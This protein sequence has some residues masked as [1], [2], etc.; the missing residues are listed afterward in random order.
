MRITNTMIIG[1]VMRNYNSIT[2]LLDRQMQQLSSGRRF[3]VPSD[4]P[5]RMLQAMRLQTNMF[6]YSQYLKNVSDARSWVE[7][8][9]TALAGA[10][11]ILQ[12]VRE[13]T[14]QAYNDP[15][16]QDSREATAIE[17]EVLLGELK[18]VGNT[19]FDGRY[20]FNGQSTTKN[21]YEMSKDNE[22][23]IEFVGDT[24]EGIIEYEI[25]PGINIE[26]NVPP[27]K[28]FDNGSVNILDELRNLCDD[29]RNP[30]LDLVNVVGRGT[31]SLGILQNDLVFQI[32][33][34]RDN[35]SVTITIT[36]GSS[37]EEA[38]AQ[39]N[40][41]LAQ[42]GINQLQA[43][44]SPKKQLI[45]T[46]KEET[47]PGRFTIADDP[48]SPGALK[49]VTGMY[50]GKLMSYLKKIDVGIDN[51]L[52]W[53]GEMGARVNRL[54]LTE[55]RLQEVNHYSTELINEQAYID[56]AE[57]ITQLKMQENLQRAALAVG[58]RIIQPTLMD[59]LR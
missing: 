22:G 39:I 27:Q 18:N 13:L 44:L 58:A 11:N 23:Y 30:E 42:A 32:N 55:N 59:F 10:E 31:K 7:T 2:R 24:G 20:I 9:E 1:N 49:D 52:R 17:I 45:F 51:L 33:D 15:Q 50:P 4:D 12:R 26:I 8:T 47:D 16:S 36:G 54:E 38:V 6:E 41:Q 25:S 34:S 28:I 57:M 43:S 53:Q 3:L 5:V 56:F 46:L 35:Q 29:L 19:C 37:A 14:V 40:Q 21:P 48:A